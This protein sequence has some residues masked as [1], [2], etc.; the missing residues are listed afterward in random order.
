MRQNFGHIHTTLYSIS[1]S[2]SK[3]SDQLHPLGLH[4]VCSRNI[5]VLRL[6]T[7][8]NK[9]VSMHMNHIHHL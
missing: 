5:S 6:H 4:T 9:S 3:I 7:S 2:R 1:M 8:V